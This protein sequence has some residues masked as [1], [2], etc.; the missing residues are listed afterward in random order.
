M[1]M[2]EVEFPQWAID[3]NIRNRGREH[4]VISIEPAKTALII[5][6]IQ[7]AWVEP[8][9]SP[10]YIEAAKDI[11][12]NINRLSNVMRAIGGHVVFTQHCWGEWPEFFEMFSNQAFKDEAIEK[13]QVGTHGHALWPELDVEDDDIMVVK[14][15]PSAFIQG[16]SDMDAVL[17]SKGIDTVIITGTL[18]N[19]CC[20]SSARDAAALNYRV[21]FAAD[22]TAT[23]SA[24]E[25]NS[26]LIN[27]GQYVADIRFTDEL[28]GF[29]ESQAS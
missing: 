9:Y 12:P 18:T 25:H 8:G 11:V 29:L 19:A 5:I 21:I 16:S 7:N 23:R 14:T 24:Q 28:T 6:D 15:R 27:L 20:E 13:T 26:T 4:A 22:A 1:Q 3:R 2:Y 17:K 10:L